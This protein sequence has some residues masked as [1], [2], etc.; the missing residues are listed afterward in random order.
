[1]NGSVRGCRYWL[2]LLILLAAV[3]CNKRPGLHIGDSLP[4]L[5]LTDVHNNNVELPGNL[6]GKVLLLRFWSLECHFCDKGILLALEPLYQKYKNQ[7]FVPVAINAGRI[8]NDDPRL[9]KFAGLSYPFLLDV[10][11][12]NAKKLGVVGLPATFVFDEQ[13]ILRE[14]LTG[15]AD[16]TEFEKLFTTVLNKGGFYDST[17]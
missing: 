16:I 2:V 12:L 5:A 17:P 15:E 3:S 8:Q 10:Y 7:G 6:K 9:Q 14:K 11:G 1:M 4:A 13:G